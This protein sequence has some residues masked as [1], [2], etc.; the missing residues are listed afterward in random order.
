MG[1]V[2]AL[3]GTPG[4]G[5]SVVGQLLAVE[6]GIQCLELNQIILEQRLYLGE[7]ADRETLIA[8]IEK[9]R[10][11]LLNTI[12][13]GKNRYV[14]VGHFA[15]EVPKDL[16][17]VLI[18]LRCNPVILSQRLQKKG[19]SVGKI[20]ENLQAE[21]LGECTAQAIA[22]HDLGQIFELDTSEKNPQ[23][24]VETINTILAGKGSN[25]AVGRISWL[26]S[27]DEQLVYQIME[28]NM[29]PS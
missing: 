2:I 5:K 26:R 19:W 23:E 29:L 6:L 20:V 18:V 7:D 9:V 27:L 8:D 10:E 14:V 13:E 11:Y 12:E 1:S 4:T 21:L 22:R 25:F 24:T 28:K 3:S 15:D 17:E 16:L